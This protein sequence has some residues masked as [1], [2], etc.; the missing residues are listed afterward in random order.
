[1]AENETTQ[2]Q[3]Q[4]LQEHRVFNPPAGFADKAAVNGMAAYDKLCAEAASDYEGFWAR[5]A[6]ENLDWHQPFTQTLDES[7]APFYKWFGDGQINASYN[8]LDRNLENGNADKTAIIFE[9]DDGA[10]TRVTYRELH[11]RVGPLARFATAGV[12]MGS[13]VD[14]EF[15]RERARQSSPPKGFSIVR[16]Q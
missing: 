3:N 13:N 11:A 15:T 16:A 8:C 9:A 7:D 2:D 5:L 1:M 12:R 4:G 6:R 14:D 10:V